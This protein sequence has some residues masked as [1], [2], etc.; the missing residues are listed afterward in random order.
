M[1]KL[2]STLACNTLVL[3]LVATA[4]LSVSGLGPPTPHRT[5]E[6]SLQG[7]LNA[8]TRKQRSLKANAYYE[9][10]I[11]Y[12]VRQR[13]RDQLDLDGPLDLSETDDGLE[14]IPVEGQLET[15]GDGYQHLNNKQLNKALMDYL[16]SSSH[17]GSSVQEQ[18]QPGEPIKSLFRERTASQKRASKSSTSSNRDLSDASRAE[19]AKLLEEFDTRRDDS[20][21][22]AQL[23]D[24]EYRRTLNLLMDKYRN[25]VPD[26][27]DLGDDRSMMN[28]VLFGEQEMQ[29][30]DL[31]PRYARLISAERRN[32]NAR[33]PLFN[34]DYF[35]NNY[36]DAASK[37]FPV[38]KRS[39]SASAAAGNDDDDAKATDPLVAKDLGSLFGSTQSTTTTTSTSTTALET[40][41]LNRS[42][43]QQQQQQHSH[44]HDRDH[45][46]KQGHR[47]HEHERHHLPAVLADTKDRPI[48]VRKKSVDWSQYFGI[49]RRKKKA[50]YLARPDSQDQ[51]FQYLLQKY[52]ET[53]AE[54]LNPSGGNGGASSSKDA[55]LKRDKLQ[56]VDA[57][58]RNM[59]NL[60]LEEAAQI[61]SQPDLDE[62]A[63]K[64][65]ILERMATA[66]SLEKLRHA[67]NDLAGDSAQQ[68]QQA[69][70]Y[71]MRLLAMEQ[72]KRSRGGDNNGDD[73]DDESY[74][75]IDDG[76]GG[77]GMAEDYECPQIEIVERRCRATD[78]LIGDFKQV[79]FGP[80]VMYHVCNS[81]EHEDCLDKFAFEAGKVCAGEPDDCMEAALQLTRYPP[82]I[83]PADL[84]HSAEG[85]SCLL[86]YYIRY[87]SYNNNNNNYVNNRHHGSPVYPAYPAEN[88]SIN[89]KLQKRIPRRKQT[90]LMVLCY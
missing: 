23:Q 60:M 49:D 48:T 21:S 86:Q 66:Y 42:Q 53:M 58:L 13:P 9:L 89:R 84:C 68:Q 71:P 15:I 26:T 57:K 59:K 76:A 2:T 40:T 64:D 74:G 25:A 73:D 16:K 34:S 45:N 72:Q 31:N 30:Q 20:A 8:L 78:A 29:E 87:R 1:T 17:S 69:K 39:A 12:Q 79:L 88:S 27:S 37:R 28:D 44:N 67:L 77:G 10:P 3:L 85:D 75:M 35:N 62:Q 90:I 22:A 14:F 32:V 6:E 54:H 82:S 7:A 47:Q 70:N 46:V 11:K 80:C 38:S 19:L 83:S 51:D 18:L 41:P 36:R 56:Q 5:S 81:C 43:E 50:T 63:R 65:E 33:Y 52:Y 4:A 55:S 61:G 24:E